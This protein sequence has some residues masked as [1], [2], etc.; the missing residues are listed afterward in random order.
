MLRLGTLAH[1]YRRRLRIHAV[2]ELLAG[3]GIAV[4]VALVFSVLT[5]NSS[6]TG[7]SQEILSAI[8]G[9]ATL[10][11][12]ARDPAGFDHAMLADVRA[13]P[14]VA[15][16]SAVLEQRATLTQ[17]DRRIAIAL[18]GVDASL[19]SL[20][21]FA[22]RHFQLGGLVL[23]RGIVLPG[24]VGEALGISEAWVGRLP[25]VTLEIRGSAVRV[26]VTAVLGSGTIGPLSGAWLGVV[27]LRYAQQ[28]TG[29]HGRV[30]RVLVV[31]KA[32]QEA[33]AR[34][35]LRRIANGRLTVASTEDEARLLERATAPIDNATG[36]FAAIS[37][38]VGALFTFT[39]MLLTVPARRRFIADLRIMG[40][41]RSAVVQILGFQAI[42][43]G[44]VASLVGL[45]AGALLSLAT[46]QDPPGY[47]AFAFPLGIHRSLSASTIAL[48]FA[49]GVAASCLA[50][51]QP[52]L[53]LRRG[54]PVNAVLTEGGEPGN[55][56][57]ARTSRRMAIG[58]LALLAAS[59]AGVA[60]VPGL[61]VVGVAVI[62]LASVLLIPA[63]F[64]AVLRILDV[65]ASRWG[66]NALVLAI[67]ALGAT[68]MRSL[69]LVA[70]G[71]VAVFGSVAIEG[72]HQN[73]LH[74]LYQ[75]YREY[76]GTADLW[77]AHPGDDLALQPFDHERGLLRRVAAVPGV[78]AVR[79]YRGGLLDLGDRRV[80][81]IARPAADRT[82][83][84][85]SQ[86][87]DGDLGPAAAA[88][89]RGGWVAASRQ[90]AVDHDLELGETLVLPTPTGDVAFRLAAITTNLG[91]GP[92][93]VILNAE[94]YRRAWGSE[95][96]SAI[97]V[98]LAAGAD[99]LAVKRAVRRALGPGSS[100]EVETTAERSAHADAI[101]REGLARLSQISGLLLVATALAMAAAMGAGVWQRRTALAQ[102]RV[103]GWRPH[104]LWRALLLETSIVLGTGCLVGGATG[105]LGHYL[106]DRWLQQSTGYP[107]PFAFA[108]WQSV[109]ICALVVV[110]ALGVTAIP[111]YL[112]SRTPP[113]LGLGSTA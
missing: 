28:L 110:T 84:P 113:R 75:D 95:S 71:A 8:T 58:A 96:P 85:P 1:F 32:G 74:G 98:D 70:T 50:A 90:I 82:M 19:P 55:T 16:A 11:L 108:P 53:D 67:R 3:F 59:C 102:L 36:L 80:W 51:A 10:Q 48:A 13:L 72:A 78:R 22:A 46:T 104:K 43:L 93:A 12:A 49:G 52:L 47:L 18:V 21:G 33:A 62:A 20:G 56:I 38:F 91:W 89:R 63:T 112:V 64:A 60:L 97:E 54:R 27:S 40:F 25:P 79:A 35:G 2:Q 65:P 26:P 106:G 76:V 14:A 103:M 37:A 111:G 81:V 31:P 39:A 77:I 94:D 44:V 66:L 61:T 41:R 107:A 45:L 24:A 101:A 7:S 83:I 5:A 23:R 15:R 29:L 57:A 99:R 105:T 17:G 109:T 4:G 68:S 30:S 73:L 100:L 87:V 6:I 69:A 9:T 34:A 86:V 88:L 42:V 92:G